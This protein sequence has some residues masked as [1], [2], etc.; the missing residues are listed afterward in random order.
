MNRRATES[1][2]WTKL[3]SGKLTKRA[4]EYLKKRGISEAVAQLNNLRSLTAAQTAELWG[5]QCAHESLLVPFDKDYGSA[6]IFDLPKEMG[7]FRH[8][9]GETSRAYK[10]QM[11]NVKKYCETHMLIVEGPIKALSC[12][13]HGFKAIGIS[14]CW[15]WQK[16]RKP[17]RDLR[18]IKWEGRSVVPVFDADTSDNIGVGL[19]YVLLG[20]WLKRKG[21]R[22]GFVEMPKIAGRTTGVD[23]YLAK[24]PKRARKLSAM[25]RNA[26]SWDSCDQVEKLR[27][28]TTRTT[29]G[30]LAALFLQRHG[31]NVRHDQ[32][33]DQWYCYTGIWERQPPKAPMVQELVQETVKHIL[34]MA[35]RANSA[36]RKIWSVWARM[37]DKRSVIRGAMGLA[38]SDPIIAVSFA[39]FD[40]QPDIVGTQNGVLDLR[41]RELIRANRN[42]LVSRRLAVGYIPDAK[43]ELWE[44]FIAQVMCDK[45]GNLDPELARFMQDLCG[46]ILISGNPQRYIFFLYGEGRNG[47]SVFIETLLALMGD[48]GE[49]AQSNM[50]MRRGGFDRDSEAP[51]PFMLKLRGKRYITASEVKKGSAIDESVVK[52][53]ASGGDKITVRGLHAAP[54]DFAVEGVIMVR[55]NARPRVDTADQ[56]VW[57]RVIEIPFNYRIPD[58]A[59]DFELLRKLREELPGIL[60]W[61]LGGAERVYEKGRL[62]VPESVKKQTESYRDSMDP[63]KQFADEMLCSKAKARTP[64]SEVFRQYDLWCM[65][66][67]RPGREIE[68]GTRQEFFARMK[69]LGYRIKTYDGIRKF[70]N[71]GLKR[72]EP[73]AMGELDG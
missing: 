71:V 50:L 8:T 29:E 11:P 66:H 62:V 23:D 65:R 59:Q 3:G 24:G 45:D 52:Q 15:N 49:V 13:G 6:R 27:V 26:E 31:D 19:P 5:Q 70:K 67:S 37:C 33:E 16:D 58:D 28:A 46:Y 38:S 12:A 7:K 35:L 20:D 2:D 36:T 32:I 56:A 25:I 69:E 1:I 53:L 39:D 40:S 61:V 41:A 57:D 17:I 47:K 42:Q 64:T 21:A 68:P 10:P 34:A 43:C 55:C 60:N 14:G 30:G 9:T 44:K 54:V 73:E 63:I 51:Q 72:D 22:V 48:Y 4:I 18:A